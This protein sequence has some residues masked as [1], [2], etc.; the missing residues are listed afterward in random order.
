MQR[1][2]RRERPSGRSPSRAPRVWPRAPFGRRLSRRGGRSRPRGDRPPE[3]HVAQRNAKVEP[4]SAECGAPGRHVARAIS[5]DGE[6]STATHAAAA[7]RCRRPACSLPGRKRAGNG[8]GG[9]KASG[10]GVQDGAGRTRR[11]AAVEPKSIARIRDE[12][13]QV[14]SPLT[15]W[16][17]HLQ[18]V[19]HKAISSPRRASARACEAFGRR[20]GTARE[21]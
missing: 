20:I 6:A 3:R 13:E 10:V 4:P 17:R 7:E 5:T 12:S 1:Q 2:F 21:G 16:W 15:V 18:T 19:S 9:G 8:R 14:H 11:I